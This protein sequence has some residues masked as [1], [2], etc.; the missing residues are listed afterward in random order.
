[1]NIFQKILDAIK[2]F[3]S[4]PGL[5]TFLA[6]YEN[7]AFGLI[8]KLV[9][10]HNGAGLHEWEAEA[11]AILKADTKEIHDNWIGILI[12]LAYETFKAQQEKA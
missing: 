7:Q 10:V 12:R 11:F 4:R 3:V 1:M 8:E 9:G 5:K 6:T 2:R